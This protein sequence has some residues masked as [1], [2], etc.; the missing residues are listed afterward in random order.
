[1]C[2]FSWLVRHSRRRFRRVFA[3]GI[4]WRGAYNTMARYWTCA[5]LIPKRAS[6]I[7]TLLRASLTDY[8]DANQPLNHHGEKSEPND[9]ETTDDISP[10]PLFFIILRLS[11]F[12]FLFLFLFFLFSLSQLLDSWTPTSLVLSSCWLLLLLLTTTSFFF[13]RFFTFGNVI[14]KRNI[15]SCIHNCVVVRAV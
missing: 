12:P 2:I 8:N 7:P 6:R 11:S 10:A 14:E 13:L 1:M 9:N 15:G 3:P 4:L 5:R